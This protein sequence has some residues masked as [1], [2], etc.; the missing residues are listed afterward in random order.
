MLATFVVH[1]ILEPRPNKVLIWGEVYK[2]QFWMKHFGHGTPKRSCLWSITWPIVVFNKGKLCRK[3]NVKEYESTVRYIDGKGR[4]R[5]KGSSQLKKTQT[6]TCALVFPG[7]NSPYSMFLF[8][9]MRKHPQKKTLVLTHC[10]TMFY[11]KTRLPE[12]I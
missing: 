11:L 4:V 3:K 10:F 7:F 2:S 8:K 5:F 1:V 6:L 9:I 12:T